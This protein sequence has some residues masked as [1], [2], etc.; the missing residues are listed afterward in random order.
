MKKS[1]GLGDLKLK[2]GVSE[3]KVEKFLAGGPKEQASQTPKKRINFDVTEEEHRRLKV[4][5]A[6]EGVSITEFIWSRV[7]GDL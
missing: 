6:E 7:K 1:G 2:T 4:R 3:R 5:A